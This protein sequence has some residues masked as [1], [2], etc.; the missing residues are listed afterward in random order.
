MVPENQRVTSTIGPPSIPPPHVPPLDGD[1]SATR[2]ASVPMSMS[3]SAETRAREFIVD[4]KKLTVLVPIRTS[5]VAREATRRIQ[6]MP[7]LA[8]ELRRAAFK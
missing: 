6:R 4:P 8:L 5:V 7:M 2:A 3:I 1:A